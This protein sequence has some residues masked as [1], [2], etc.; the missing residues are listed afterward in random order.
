MSHKAIDNLLGEVERAADEA[1]V[2]ISRARAEGA[3][4]AR[5]LAHAMRRRPAVRLL[6]PW[7][8]TSSPARHGSSRRSAP[9]EQLDSS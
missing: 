5:A 7:L 8:P 6:R 1:N 2:S 4:H 3:A 9:D